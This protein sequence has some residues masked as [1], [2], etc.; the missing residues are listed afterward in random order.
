MAQA[1]RTRAPAFSRARF[2][3]LYHIHKSI[4]AKCY[5]N[6]P[7]LAK[8][9]EVSPRTIERDIEYM[10]DRLGAPIVYCYQKKGYYYENED[11]QMMPVRF[12]EG[13]LIAL[14]LGQNLLTKYSGTPLEKYIG[15]AFEKILTIMPEQVSVDWDTIE[16]AISF[17]VVPLRGDEQRVTEM[18]S[19]LAAAIEKK[20]TVW[21][22]YY[23]VVRDQTNE[24][25][26][27]PYHLRY[28]QG[29]WYVIAY[30]RLRGDIRIFALDRIRDLKQTQ[31]HFTKVKGFSINEYFKSALGIEH[32]EKPKKVTIRFDPHQ[33]RWIRERCWHPSQKL[34]FKDDGSLL[35]TMTVSSLKEV[36]RW[37]LGFGRHAEVIGPAQLRQEVAEEIENTRKV[38]N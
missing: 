28:H 6:V 17:N 33:A 22:R 36:K 24:R 34:E 26:I 37:V 35:L 11:F 38:Y 31:R 29:A 20:H 16:Q 18:Y 32:G 1:K 8:Q 21:M 3:R 7:N 19:T 2:A 30:C 27:D 5:P 10:R 9:F 15:S 4:C 12:T 14:F 25:Y 13:E 23:G